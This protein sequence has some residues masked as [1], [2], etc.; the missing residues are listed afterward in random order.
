MDEDPV[1]TDLLE[2]LRIAVGDRLRIGQGTFRI[3]A[4][5]LS[6]P[7][8]IATAF[9]T[10]PRVLL[11]RDGLRRAE[12]VR[13]TSFGGLYAGWILLL[14]WLI[15]VAIIAISTLKPIS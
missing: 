2:R 15:P 7:D 10:G 1:G 11:S 5:L 8:R 3:R 6:E 13:S 14:K 9:A 4:E 12:F